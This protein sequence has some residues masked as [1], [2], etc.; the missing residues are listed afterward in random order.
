MIQFHPGDA[1]QINLLCT[2][3]AQHWHE[4]GHWHWRKN[5]KGKRPQE[6]LGYVGRTNT[7]EPVAEQTPSQLWGC[8]SKSIHYGCDA[9]FERTSAKLIT[10]YHIVWRGGTSNLK[11]KKHP[12]CN[13]NMAKTMLLEEHEGQIE[14]AEKGRPCLQKCWNIRPREN[15]HMFCLWQKWSCGQGLS[16]P[17]TT[18]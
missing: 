8:Y 17:K 10:K 2:T 9:I 12:L 7:W 15:H 3:I 4:G 18:S 5:L 14:E 1:S 13:I 6:P 11:M 16:W